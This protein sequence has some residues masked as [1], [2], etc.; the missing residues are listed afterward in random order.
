MYVRQLPNGE[1]VVKIET[2][3]CEEVIVWTEK[4]VFHHSCYKKE[5]KMMMMNTKMMNTKMK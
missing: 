2:G 5:K 3:L 4:L 1:V